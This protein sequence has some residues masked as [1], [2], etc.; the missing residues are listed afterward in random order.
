MNKIDILNEIRQVMVDDEDEHP[1]VDNN[2][3]AVIQNI[4][5]QINKN[6]EYGRLFRNI[7]D[8]S[9]YHIRGAVK[10]IISTTINT[11][12]ISRIKLIGQKRK[13]RESHCP[14]PG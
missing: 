14:I 2:D 5:Q 6:N 11:H 3:H 10:T 8:L 9:Q 1:S 4:L 13:K 7:E 12:Y